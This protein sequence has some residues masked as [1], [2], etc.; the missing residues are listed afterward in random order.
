M[1][2]DIIIPQQGEMG[3]TMTKSYILTFLTITLQ[4]LDQTVIPLPQSFLY[5]E[6]KM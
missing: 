5:T 6:L 3:Y 2:G 1:A 4:G